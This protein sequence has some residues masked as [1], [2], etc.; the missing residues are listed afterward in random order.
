MWY[1]LCWVPSGGW[2]IKHDFTR[3]RVQ[4]SVEGGSAICLVQ[5]VLKKG[6][7]FHSFG[8][9]L[10]LGQVETGNSSTK[11][12]HCQHVCKKVSH[13]ATWHLKYILSCM[14]L[15]KVCMPLLHVCMYRLMS[16][17][18]LTIHVSLQWLVCHYLHA[19]LLWY[20]IICPMSIFIHC[21]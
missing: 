1:L 17:S 18:W 21:A 15:T 5:S 13:L 9:A 20:V 2:S 19:F 4:F 6:T 10:Y 16:C 11:S 14:W 8:Y 12:H 3:S 7:A